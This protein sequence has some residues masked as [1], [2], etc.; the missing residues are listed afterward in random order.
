MGTFLYRLKT[1]LALAG[2]GMPVVAAA[3][4]IQSEREHWAAYARTGEAQLAEAVSALQRLYEQSSDA[5]VRAD[6]TALLLRQGRQGDALAVCPSCTPADYRTDE[7]E[8]LAKAARD[9]RQ[10]EKALSLYQILQQRDPK[11]KIGWL[12]GALTSVELGDY[13]AAQN[14]IAAY[15]KR[16][17]N[18]RDI[19]AA[20]DYLKL[21]TQSLAERMGVLQSRLKQSPGDKNTVVELYRTATGLHAYPMLEQLLTDY[22]QFFNQKDRMWL[23]YTESVSH[24]RASREAMSHQ[25]SLQAF[26]AL[27]E[28]VEQSEPGSELYLRALRDRVVAGVMIGRY[29]QAQKDYQKLERWGEQPDFVRDAYAQ[30]LSAEGSP[31][32]AARIY[33][34]IAA[35]QDAAEGQVTTE[36]VEKQVQTS[37]DL[38]L[39]SRAQEELTRLNPSGKK[40]VPDFT[41][42]SEVK[43]PYFDKQYFWQVRLEAWNGNMK[44]AIRM[45]DRW[46]AEHP[47]DPWAMILRGE[48]AQ[49]NGRND[50]AEKW[51]AEAMPWIP[52]DSRVWV[53]T[54]RGSILMNNGNWAGVKEMAAGIDRN[55]PDYK[56]FWQRYDEARAARLSISGGVN[57]TTSPSD[58]GNEWSQNATLYSPRSEGGH[59]AYITQQSGFVPNHGNELRYGR[60]G[61]GGEFSLYPFT[62]NIESG[63]GTQLNDKAYVSAG[64]GYRHNQNW[65]FHAR[66]ATNSANTPT[67]AWEQGVYANEYG[68]SANYT[69]SGV[70][71]AGFG[72]GV[73]AFDD[74]NRRRSGYVWL[75]QDIWQH[76]RWRIGGSLWADF[77][78]N[79]EIAG[80]Y[81]YNPKSSK[82]L[83]GDLGLT[84]SLPLDNNIRFSQTLGVGAGRYWQAGELA[85]NTWMVKLGH[86]WSLGKRLG[87]SYEAGRKKTVYDGEA[88]YQNFGNIGVN[89]RFE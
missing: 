38:G 56:G 8:N 57:K 68:I 37:A 52:P 12:G 10:F 34:E 41:H 82:T 32:R 88:E 49:W 85:E 77:S 84:Y 65:S 47:A 43:N 81:Y 86:D 30:A 50:E 63:R 13:T 46:L 70:T 33:Q 69:H 61:A 71:R 67:K 3:A 31:H 20:E 72:L 35:R 15:R 17:G 42:T 59:R 21:E 7:L 22:P 4:D 1:V 89:F 26:Q 16:F 25:N 36:I 58:S 24:L 11:Q 53:Q 74:G 9:S 66:A 83:S 73:L 28:V 64:V 62:V 60:I 40:M 29:R 44:A 23:T 51:F 18:D 48:L 55:D 79:D 19:G 2:F 78:R 6:L 14:H 27:G 87:V 5:R 45:M 76:N 54:N 39:Y 75:S 80:T